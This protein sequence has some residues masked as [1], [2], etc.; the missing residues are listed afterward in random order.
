LRIELPA[1]AELV[2]QP[3]ADP[4]PIGRINAKVAAVEHRV[5]VGPEQQS[6]VDPVLSPDRHWPNMGCLEYGPDLRARD[7]AMTVVGIEHDRLESLLREPIWRKTRITEHGSGV[8]PG[9]TQVDLYLCAEDE[10]HEI[11]EV[12]G[13]P[14]LRHIVTF[15]LDNVGGESGWRQIS[16]ILGEECHIPYE[17]APNLGIVAKRD[18][19]PAVVRDSCPHPFEA[20]RAVGETEQ[21]PG[22]GNAKSGESAVEAAADDA[23]VRAVRLKEEGFADGQCT[24]LPASPGS[25]E[26]HFCLG[27]L[28]PCG[29]K[30]VP[31]VVGHAYVTPHN[32]IVHPR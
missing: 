9:L 11:S 1:V 27:D 26:I 18:R 24:K 19:G 6:V 8:V 13:G 30:P 12:A 10:L 31:F 15:P 16:G 4:Q 7:G 14:G 20:V 32:G 22:L 25:P 5:H 17:N 23:V 29:K 21:L 3:W 28:R 2:P